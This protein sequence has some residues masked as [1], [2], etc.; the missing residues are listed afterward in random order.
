MGK[1]GARGVASGSTRICKGALRRLGHVT[2]TAKLPQRLTLTESTRI[3]QV[4]SRA[5][6]TS[7]QCCELVPKVRVGGG[8]PAKPLRDNA[9]PLAASVTQEREA[10]KQRVVALTFSTPPGKSSEWWQWLARSCLPISRQ[11]ISIRERY[12]SVSKEEG[13][14]G[15]LLPRVGLF[16]PCLLARS[17]SS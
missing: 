2:A 4:G 6:C 10:T 7:L 13:R 11:I 9:Q 12:I 8:R 14:R 15:L 16:S 1:R 3:A 17:S 5:F